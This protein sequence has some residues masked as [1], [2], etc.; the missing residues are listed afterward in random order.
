VLREFHAECR[1]A[2]LHLSK[3]L[4][5]LAY[6]FLIVV[7]AARRLAPLQQALNHRVLWAVEEDHHRR[8]L[9][10]LLER[11]RL[12]RSALAKRQEVSSVSARESCCPGLH[13]TLPRSSRRHRILCTFCDD[14]QLG[15]LELSP[16][17]SACVA[18]MQTTI[19]K[20]ARS[21][22]ITMAV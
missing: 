1:L 12:W 8:L 5:A 18:V 13:I 9:Q 15:L 6:G 14:Y 11:L 10:L 17:V 3:G 21:K 4:K 20:K 16:N 19:N 7:G 22:N 2:K